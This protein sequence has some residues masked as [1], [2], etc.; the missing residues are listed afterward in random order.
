M[1]K[2]TI[3]KFVESINEEYFTGGKEIEELIIKGENTTLFG[4]NNF[5]FEEIK[6]FHCFPNIGLKASKNLKKSEKI[7]ILDN[8]C[9][10]IKKKSFKDWIGLKKIILPNSLE[11]IE[12]S[13]FENCCN[14]EE[15]EIPLS[16]KFVDISSFINCNKLH[17]IK[18]KSEFFNC[19]Q[20]KNNIKKIIII[21][22]S[23]YI[24]PETIKKF[25]NL[26]ILELPN[27]IQNLQIDL[28]NLTKLVEIKCNEQV[29][30]NLPKES[31]KYFQNIEIIKSK[32]IIDK[33]VFKG[34]ENAQNIRIENSNSKI[35]Y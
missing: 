4:N 17:T 23:N 14:L 9:K 35:I 5:D 33:E 19:F 31:K 32:E 28:S 3:P 2:V 26:E 13:A 29:L 34:C 20:N 7:I 12:E 24:N 21:E 10:I 30:K 25:Q 16:V 1:K 8:K 11:I 18:C 6:I 27:S 15:I 22:G